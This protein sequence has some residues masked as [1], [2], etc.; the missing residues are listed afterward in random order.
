MLCE[1]IHITYEFVKISHS[2]IRCYMILFHAGPNFL[3]LF[4]WK[5]LVS[6]ENALQVLE[7]KFCFYWFVW[8]ACI[9]SSYC[10]SGIKLLFKFKIYYVVHKQHNFPLP[11]ILPDS[12]APFA[13]LSYS[14]IQKVWIL[15]FNVRQNDNLVQNNIQNLTFE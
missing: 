9:L 12:A 1:H 14:F 3:L 13:I 11:K 2:L 4:L 5:S 7:K 8:V 6:C 10:R 15:K